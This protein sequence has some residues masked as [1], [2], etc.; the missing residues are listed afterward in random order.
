MVGHRR[1]RTFRALLIRYDVV[2][3]KQSQPAAGAQ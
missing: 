1:C 3:W 2:E